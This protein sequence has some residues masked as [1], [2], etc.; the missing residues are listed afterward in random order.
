MIDQRDNLRKA[1]DELV[2]Q[3]AI[4]RQKEI[5][6]EKRIEEYA[7]KRDALDQLRKDK[8]E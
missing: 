5:E 6:H 4:E 7:K 2:A 3:G 1:N 8:E